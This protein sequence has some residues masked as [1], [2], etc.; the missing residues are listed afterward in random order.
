M[1]YQTKI[2]DHSVLRISVGDLDAY[3]MVFEKDSGSWVPHGAVVYWDCLTKMAANIKRMEESRMWTVKS[4]ARPLT[5]KRVRTDGVVTNM[6]TRITEDPALFYARKVLHRLSKHTRS[7]VAEV[8]AQ[9]GAV[10]RYHAFRDF[11]RSS[12]VVFT[13]MGS[14]ASV[15]MPLVKPVI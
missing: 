10:M 6:G 4:E 12:K 1:Y 8:T 9:N 7:V 2:S 3:S 13:P 11:E 15:S 5:L 14:D